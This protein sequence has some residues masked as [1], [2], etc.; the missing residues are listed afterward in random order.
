MLTHR[1][2][3]PPPSPNL[4]SVPPPIRRPPALQVNQVA[5]ERRQRAILERAKAKG[6]SPPT[7]RPRPPTRPA[8]HHHPRPSSSSFSSSIS[9]SLS[10]LPPPFPRTPPLLLFSCLF[11]L[12]LLIHIARTCSSF[13]RCPPPPTILHLPLVHQHF[14]QLESTSRHR[15]Q[16]STPP[17]Q[18]L[19][20]Y[21]CSTPTFFYSS[22]DTMQNSMD[23]QPLGGSPTSVHSSPLNPNSFNIM[24]G[25]EASTRRQRIAMACQYCRHRYVHRTP[26]VDNH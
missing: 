7:T 23:A 5:W 17:A 11:C 1:T 18:T 2:C 8:P 6:S 25:S 20:Y 4:S 16:C 22:P 14:R 3:S 15:A 21:H 26:S 12:S 10:S 9:T 24:S 19:R 13:L